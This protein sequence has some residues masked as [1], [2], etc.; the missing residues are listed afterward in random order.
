MVAKQAKQ[1]K[2][3]H[4]K[5]P[6]SLSFINFSLCPLA[7]LRL[8]VSQNNLFGN[9]NVMLNP[10]HAL[11]LPKPAVTQYLAAQRPIF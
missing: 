10:V 3:S 11:I 4:A 7:S 1:V 5:S 9:F 8:G 2:L 6:S